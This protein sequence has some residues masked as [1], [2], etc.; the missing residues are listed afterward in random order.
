MTG[1]HYGDSQ[2]H[3]ECPCCGGQA[4]AEFVDVGVGMVQCQPYECQ[5]CGA[6]QGAEDPQRLPSGGWSHGWAVPRNA[7]DRDDAV[8]GY[9]VKPNGRIIETTWDRG[10]REI[11]S[12][13]GTTEWALRLQGWIRV[14]NLEGFAVS[15]PPFV[16]AAAAKALR[17]VVECVEERW[18]LPYVSHTGN[19]RGAQMGLG[20]LMSAVARLPRQEGAPDAPDAEGAAG[21]APR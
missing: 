3:E 20:E 7:Q 17:E 2:P 9:Y 10:H 11:A 13:M 19:P 1:Y 16:G 6:V 5:E 12:R 18:G 21:P 8:T 14:T 4:F 15:L